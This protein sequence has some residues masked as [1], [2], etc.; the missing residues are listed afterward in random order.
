MILRSVL[1]ISV[2]AW[3]SACKSPEAR[4]PVKTS[5]GSFIKESV[6][7]NKKLIE[8]EEAII[9]SIIEKDSSHH[10]IASE[11]GFWYYYNIKDTLSTIQPVVGDDVVFTYDIRLLNGDTILSETETG[12]QN[13]KVDQTNQSLISGIRD[14]I[15]LMKAGEQITFL[16]PSHKAYGYY[17]IENK[18]GTNIPV[19]STV[20]LKT[21]NS[22]DNN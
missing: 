3:F 15:K 4:R 18:L 12:I 9:S 5:S 21:I 8:E 20:T 6:E 2:L 13:Y 16:F 14:G 17:G 22:T 19:Q 1:L 11:S 10:F 7:R